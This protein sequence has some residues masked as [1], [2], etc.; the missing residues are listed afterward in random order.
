MFID[1]LIRRHSRSQ[2]K[3]FMVFV[4]LKL[5]MTGETPDI[6]FDKRKQREER[7]ER[8]KKERKREKKCPG[9]II[10]DLHLNRKNKN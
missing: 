3:T 6:C 9:S 1:N 7:G 8:E 5:K 2:I 10:I 4:N